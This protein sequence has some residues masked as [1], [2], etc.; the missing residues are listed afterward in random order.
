MSDTT[1]M[2]RVLPFPAFDKS[3]DRETIRPENW[4]DL[5]DFLTNGSSG[6]SVA[7]V[8]G[9]PVKGITEGD[10]IVYDIQLE[11]EPGDY[12]LNADR[13][14]SEFESGTAFGVITCIIKPQVSH[15]RQRQGDSTKEI[16]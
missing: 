9:N 11:P 1:M 14:V 12:V 4:L 16:K 7:Q 8:R 6:V 3:I 10:L 15:Q 13:Q 2:W 5:A